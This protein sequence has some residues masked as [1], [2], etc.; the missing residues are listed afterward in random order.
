M[1]DDYNYESFNKYILIDPNRDE[2]EED[3][4]DLGKFVPMPVKIL[5][6]KGSKKGESVNDDQQSLHLTEKELA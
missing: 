4:I 5:S 3:K 2:T 1:F 6:A